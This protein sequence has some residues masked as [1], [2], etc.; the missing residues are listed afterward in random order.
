MKKCKIDIFHVKVV[1]KPIVN[2]DKVHQVHQVHGEQRE[3][4]GQQENEVPKVFG[5]Q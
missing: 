5:A 1:Y 4:L 2:V 3:Q